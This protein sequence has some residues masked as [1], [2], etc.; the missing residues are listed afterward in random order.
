MKFGLGKKSIC[1]WRIQGTL[2]AL[3][4]CFLSGAVA[5]LLPIAGITIC[6]VVITIY[7]LYFFW[8]TPRLFQTAYVS[9]EDGRLTWKIGLLFTV[10]TSLRLESILTATISHTPLQS[11][12][13]LCTLSVR[14]VGAPIKLRQ[15][16]EK[17][18][19]TLMQWIEEAADD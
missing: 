13:G 17:D 5:V 19:R 6:I 1:L 14:P 12:L 4:F 15:L 16:A 11:A 8:Y 3:L 10:K 7:L 18:A 2:A 9:L